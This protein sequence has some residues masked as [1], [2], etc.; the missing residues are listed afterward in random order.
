MQHPKQNSPTPALGEGPEPMFLEQKCSA[1]ADRSILKP[2]KGAGFSF[3][4]AGTVEW[5]ALL[6]SP[7]CGSNIEA[8]GSG[9]SAQIWPSL[10][11]KTY[12]YAPAASALDLTSFEAGWLLWDMEMRKVGGHTGSKGRF[13]LGICGE[14]QSP[15]LCTTL[16]VIHGSRAINSPNLNN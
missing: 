7:C 8:R 5:T 9:I 1:P 10:L 14:L 3:L 11:H 12:G 4:Q 6:C 2:G 16:Q 13:C 15:L